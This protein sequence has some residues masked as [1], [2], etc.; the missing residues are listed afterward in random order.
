M[1]A[2]D[3][4]DVN[5]SAVLRADTGVGDDERHPVSL[6]QNLRRSLQELNQILGGPA[7]EE[8]RPSP[9]VLVGS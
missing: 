7:H 4:A 9:G 1:D 3:R 5:A 8:A 2:V 6:Y